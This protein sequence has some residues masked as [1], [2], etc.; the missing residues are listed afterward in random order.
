MY[1][2]MKL[3]TI[4]FIIMTGLT[5]GE[6][7]DCLE[8]KERHVEVV[9]A[10]VED[11]EEV[12]V[13]AHHEGTLTGTLTPQEMLGAGRVGQ[14]DLIGEKTNDEGEHNSRRG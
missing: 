14:V 4:A 3:F 6:L 9:C 8:P 12:V 13:A 11:D 10:G 5:V 7:E 2:E 1:I